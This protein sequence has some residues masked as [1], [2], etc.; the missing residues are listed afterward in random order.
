M[1]DGSIPDLRRAA[2][3]ALDAV[4]STALARR[5]GPEEAHARLSALRDA[6]RAAVEA[7]GGWVVDE[8]GDGILAAFGAHA[9]VESA[10]L[11]ACRAALDARGRMDGA[12]GLQIRIGL[13]EGPVMVARE[14]RGIAVVGDAVVL[15]ARL[16]AAAAP[17]EILLDPALASEAGAAIRVEARQPLD[18]KGFD[19]PVSPAALLDLAGPDLRFG[20]DRGAPPLAE[21]GTEL[22][23]GVAAFAGAARGRTVWIEGEA[24]IGKSRLA[25]EI[26]R[27]LAD[28]RAV[29]V[30]RCAPDDL[31][32]DLAPVFDLLRDAAGAARGLPRAVLLERLL[33]E[34]PRSGDAAALAAF[35]EAGGRAATDPVGRAEAT[36]DLL[37][38]LLR[39]VAARRDAV[40]WVE[41]VH[42]IDGASRTILRDLAAEPI[43]L[44]L[45]ARPGTTAQAFART[46]VEIALHPLG[47]AGV[48]R[49]AEAAADGPIS[50]GLAAFVAAR[51]EGLPFA[52]EEIVRALREDGRL[53][54]RDG[55]VELVGDPGPALTGNVQQL[56]LSRLDRLPDPLREALRLAALVGREVD[57]GVVSAALGY[58]AGLRGAMAAPGL[59]EPTGDGRW[60]FAHALVRDAIAESV[61]P[62]R[63]R[64][65]HGRILDTLTAV[66]G[67]DAGEHAGRLAGHALAA[68]REAEGAGHLVRAAA[69]RLAGYAVR[70]A[71]RDCE[72]AAEI[73]EGAVGAPAM[74]DDALYR[75]L[76]ATWLRGLDHLGNYAALN[77]VAEALLPRLQS[78]GHSPELTLA[79]TLDAIALCHLR[80]YAGAEAL[81]QRSL[82][83]SEAAA[84][85][86]GAAWARAALM[87]HH[88]ETGRP[89]EE[90]ERLAALIAPVARATGDIHLEMTALYLLSSALR[91]AGRRLESLDAIARLEAVEA[92]CGD[93]RAGAYAAWARALLHAIEDDPQRVRAT[94]APA[95]ERAI[96]GSGDERV[97]RAMDLYARVMLEAP[98]RVLPEVDALLAEAEAVGDIN[99]AHAVLWLRAVVDL[100]S[101][102]LRAAWRRIAKLARLVEAAGNVNLIRQVLLLR[103]EVLLAIGGLP[104]PGRR[105]SVGRPGLP[106]LL[107]AA[108]LRIGARRRAAADLRRCLALDLSGRGS[109][110]ARCEMGLARI[111]AAARREAEARAHL[112]RARGAA[113]TEGLDALETAATRALRDLER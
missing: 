76:A 23:E 1:R 56:V 83:E 9:G 30:G 68:G 19:A 71:V 14:G 66:E 72:R 31:G 33:A 62:S 16:E 53:A 86:H 113:A 26:G 47:E 48:R 43:D 20:P 32:A 57:E 96:P 98:D 52:A 64:E 67:G 59:V 63:L 103:G 49:I 109:H 108:R 36:R 22:A 60:R 37:S 112:Q 94:V 39:R 55:A 85:A 28:G 41:D 10:A 107:T 82:S 5:L 34:E 99:I 7:A 45:T 38:D 15:A 95:L 79:R 87:R 4:G 106:D 65:A 100:R 29:L 81:A 50:A 6:A 51:A 88:D 27:Q 54:V 17:G 104:A 111:A 91:S 92:R 25:H 13:A 78:M 73:A 40:L 21:R 12:A 8:A 89:T 105:P 3:L 24:G 110:V 77:R 61:L 46:A 80:D 84:D 97:G 69:H 44:L 93:R 2:I 101:G 58:P 75:S 90:I 74:L 18:L 11:L 42:W 70:E 35:H 102:R